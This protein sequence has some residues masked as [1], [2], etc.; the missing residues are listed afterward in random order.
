M[1]RRWFLQSFRI[2][3]GACPRDRISSDQDDAS[4]AGPPCCG[5]AGGAVKVSPS[6]SGCTDT[7]SSTGHLSRATNSC[8]GRRADGAIAVR[9]PILE[10]TPTPPLA[11]EAIEVELR[12]HQVFLRC[13]AV[14]DD[15]PARIHDQAFA[16][17]ERL[18]RA[19]RVLACTAR[20]C[21][22]HH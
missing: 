11:F 4:L 3:P 14:P 1:T 12:D 9:A 21:A 6:R 8:C 19:A 22:G 17:V 7:R 2:G 10:E 20:C 15:V 18:R 16:E 5:A 13:A